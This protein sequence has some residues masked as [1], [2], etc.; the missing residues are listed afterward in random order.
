MWKTIKPGAVKGCAAAI[1]INV[2]PKV[3]KR[4]R[5]AVKKKKKGEEGLNISDLL[6][7]KRKKKGTGR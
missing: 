7:G 5:W 4:K 3:V 1:K 2:P 6:K